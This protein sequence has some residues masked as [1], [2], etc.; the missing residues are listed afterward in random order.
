LTD[1]I[2]PIGVAQNTKKQ[3]IAMSVFGEGSRTLERQIRK[4]KLGGR[5][6]VPNLKYLGVFLADNGKNTKEISARLNA[7]WTKWY[8][9]SKLITDEDAP[10]LVRRLCLIN[11][12]Y[13]ALLSGTE[14]FVFTDA[15]YD[16]LNNFVF[17]RCRA[18][19]LGKAHC[20]DSNDKHTS[21]SNVQVMKKL[22]SFLCNLN[23]L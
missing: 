13:N 18:L 2:R 12:V 5:K 22:V 21:I 14:S 11:M 23:S 10:F 8:M 15:E 17:S 4:D 3:E 9:F 7:A 20:K 19:L 6:L 1:N 16:K